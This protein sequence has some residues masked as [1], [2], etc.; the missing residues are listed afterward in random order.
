M[1]KIIKY[2]CYS[3]DIVKIY[4]KSISFRI[5]FVMYGYRSYGIFH[6]KIISLKF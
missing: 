5:C 6:I 2:L 1:N 3:Q 4:I